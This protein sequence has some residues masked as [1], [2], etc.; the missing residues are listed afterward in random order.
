MNA[1]EF[2]SHLRNLRGTE[3]AT[4][5]ETLLALVEFDRRELY[6][7]LGYDKLWTYLI[8]VLHYCEGATY[9][10]WRAVKILQRFPR[11]AVQLRDGRLNLTTLVEL[12]PVLEDETVDAV[13]AQAAYMSKTVVKALVASLRPVEQPKEL[14]F[15]RAPRP[16]QTP[17]IVEATT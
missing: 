13:T 12:E 11:L 9:R 7:E 14:G 1:C 4:E 2:D 16:A 5:V 8:K 3:R 17:A 10:R 15:R 6:L